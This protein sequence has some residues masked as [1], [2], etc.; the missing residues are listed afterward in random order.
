MNVPESYPGN[1]L[2]FDRARVA[3]IVNARLGEDELVDA[4]KQIASQPLSAE[5]IGLFIEETRKTVVGKEDLPPGAGLIDVSGT[6]GSGLAHFNTSTFCAFVLAAG[7]VSVGKFGNR[8]S[9]SGAGSAD[10][11]EALG[12]P[13]NLPA[14]RVGEVIERAGVAF[15]FAPHYYPGLKKLAQARKAVGQPTIFNHIG[16]LLNPIEPEYR[17]FGMTSQAAASLAAQYLQES[18]ARVLIVTSQTGLDELMPGAYNHVFHVDKGVTQD[19]SFTAPGASL[20]DL[21][22]QKSAN[23]GKP[24]FDLQH[25][26]KLFNRLMESK[27]DSETQPWLDLVCLNAGA[28]FFVAGIADDVNAGAEHARDLIFSGRV[29]EKFD[30][31]RQVYEKCAA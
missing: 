14:A 25:N 28:G 26:L 13:L 3:D 20:L 21:L 18:G 30:Q 5:L 22:E 2:P 27:S 19:L 31:V 12:I 29:K 9:R 7:G 6:G 17:V 8:A 16:P 10:L 15:L 23:S 24:Q 11:L 4:L 1:G